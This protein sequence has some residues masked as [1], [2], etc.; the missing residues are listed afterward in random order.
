M[1]TQQAD[2][3]KSVPNY[4]AE[5]NSVREIAI[6]GYAN[7]GFWRDYLR[8]FELT[9]MSDDHRTRLNYTVN[10]ARWMGMSFCEATL[11][12]DVE[13]RKSTNMITAFL[14]S[15]VNTSRFLSL[16]ERTL[17]RT[18]YQFGSIDLQLEPLTQLTARHQDGSLIN[19]TKSQASDVI[20]HEQETWEGLVYLPPVRNG[21]N[22]SM[23]VR[24][25]GA[26][27]VYPFDA[28]RDRWSVASTDDQ[29]VS[30]LLIRSDFVPTE[31]RVRPDGAHARSKTYRC[32]PTQ[33]S[34]HRQV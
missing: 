10:R 24:L 30:E 14:V 25:S 2:S 9:P 16:C 33:W 23:Y 13:P 32:E 3:A 6:R 19:A 18:P 28:E 17:F 21:S 12:I 5:V 26:V 11:V 27:D 15:A 8:R 7:T 1:P 31:W 4:I 22:E 34:Q 29:Q 20:R